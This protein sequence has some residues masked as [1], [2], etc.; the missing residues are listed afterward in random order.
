[1]KP[2]ALIR[3]VILMLAWL[4]PS[5]TAL[6]AQASTLQL[7]FIFEFSG[8]QAPAGPTPWL[9][10]VFD[11]F[12]G[13]GSVRLT[14]SSS[15]LVNSENVKEW[16]FNLNPALDPTALIYTYNAGLST[17]AAAVSIADGV[18][19]CKADGDGKYDFQ[20]SFAPSSGFTPG[21][22]VVY[23]ITGIGSLTAASFNYLS[24]PAGGHGPYL[25][26]AHVQNTTGAGSGG[27]GWVAGVATSTIPVPAAVWMFGSALGLLGWIRR[28]C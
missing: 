3:P 7:N 11:D 28:R 17:A 18:D 27:S 15:G 6:Q 19:C 9:T 12:G 5:M 21:K 24:A 25:S 8:A 14:M 10:A 4:A 2:I 13:T 20:F 22:T 1:M 16:Y 26:A 23:D